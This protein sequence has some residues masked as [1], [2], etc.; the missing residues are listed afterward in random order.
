LYSEKQSQLTKNK[1]DL[2]MTTT[3]ETKEENQI[4]RK[5]CAYLKG[6]IVGYSKRHGMKWNG[7]EDGGT[8]EFK[9]GWDDSLRCDS[10]TITLTHIIYNRIRH[11]RP[12]CGVDKDAEYIREHRWRGNKFLNALAEMGYPVSEVL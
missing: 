2:I 1:G 3:T 9:Q 12:H 5:A 8:P 10:E 6:Y 7:D 4:H 11:D